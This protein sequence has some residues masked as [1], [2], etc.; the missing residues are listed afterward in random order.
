LT[1]LSAV[2]AGSAAAIGRRPALTRAANRR[3]HT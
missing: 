1:A 3:R 2:N